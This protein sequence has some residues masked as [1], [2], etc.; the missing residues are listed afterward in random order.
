MTNQ[1][2]LIL[3]TMYKNRVAKR[4]GWSKVPVVKVLVRDG[5]LMFVMM[6]GWCYYPNCE[7]FGC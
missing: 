4:D 1:L 7:A 2:L 6:S 3:L 5:V